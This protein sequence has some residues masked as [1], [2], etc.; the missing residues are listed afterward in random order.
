[1]SHRWVI[2][3]SGHRHLRTTDDFDSQD[4]AEEWLRDNW[5]SL[6]A[7]GASFVVLK[8]DDRIV[9]EMGLEPA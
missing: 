3:D 7:D 9:Y 8:T 1:M 4:A 5:E 2:H 6:V